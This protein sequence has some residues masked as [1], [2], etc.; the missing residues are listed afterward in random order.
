MSAASFDRMRTQQQLQKLTQVADRGL[1][2]FMLREIAIN[3]ISF[4]VALAIGL[5]ML[6]FM[7]MYRHSDLKSAAIIVPLLSILFSVA[8]WRRLQRQIRTLRVQLDMNAEI[9]PSKRTST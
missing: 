1:C 3:F 7:H 2:R 9:A 8:S 5:L 4:G 6:Q